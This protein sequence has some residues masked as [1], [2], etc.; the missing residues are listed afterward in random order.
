MTHLRTADSTA[1]TPS[2]DLATKLL[3]LAQRAARQFEFG[4]ALEYL[5]TIE[6]TWARDGMPEYHADL[7]LDLLREKGRIL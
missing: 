6:E 5:H 7:Q 2:G 4:R 1:A 3:G